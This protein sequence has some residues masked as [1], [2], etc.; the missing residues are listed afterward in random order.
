MA[1]HVKKNDL[2]QVIAGKERGKTGKVLEILSKSSRARV[3][4][5]NLVKKHLK[6]GRSPK[7][8]QGGIIDELGSIPL[9]NLMLVCPKCSKPS[10]TGRRELPDGR[11]VRFCKKCEQVIE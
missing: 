5:L 9:S 6:R 1:A 11:R 2:V 4:K 10:R 3:D 7:A 8:P